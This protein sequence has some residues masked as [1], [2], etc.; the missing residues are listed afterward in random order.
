[1][2]KLIFTLK[3]ISLSIIVVICVA[4]EKCIRDQLSG[5]EFRNKFIRKQ[6]LTYVNLRVRRL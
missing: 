2:I 6:E 3:I 1:M 5:V 4:L